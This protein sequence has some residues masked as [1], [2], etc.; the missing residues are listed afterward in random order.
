M[1]LLLNAGSDRSSRPVFGPAAIFWRNVEI[2]LSRVHLSKSLQVA[3]LESAGARWRDG[4]AAWSPQHLSRHQMEFIC[5]SQWSPAWCWHG[6]IQHSEKKER[7]WQLEL[8]LTYKKTGKKGELVSNSE[9]FFLDLHESSVGGSTTKW[10]F[11]VLGPTAPPQTRNQQKD[12]Q[13]SLA[14]GTANQKPTER[15]TKLPC[16]GEAGWGGGGDTRDINWYHINEQL[17]L[18]KIWMEWWPPTGQ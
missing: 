8:N 7:N 18:S 12:A 2:F 3:Q 17:V 5:S 4:V 9:F 13:N 14:A 16:C 11:Q 6:V 15:R 10:S 1:C